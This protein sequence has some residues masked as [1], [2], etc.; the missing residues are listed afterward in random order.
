MQNFSSVIDAFGGA[1]SFAEAVGVSG[2]HARTMKARNSIPPAY[3]QRTVAAA[4]LMRIPN[5]TLDLLA[6]LAA[7]DIRCLEGQGD[8]A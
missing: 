6:R 3:W 7:K 4:T 2:S 1:P 5:V 8:A